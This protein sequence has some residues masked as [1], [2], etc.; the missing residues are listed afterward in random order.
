M[1]FWGLKY[2]NT[3]AQERLCR[4]IWAWGIGFDLEFIS[5]QFPCVFVFVFFYVFAYMCISVFVNLR[6]CI[7]QTYLSMKDWFWSRIHRRP[8]LLPLYL[9]SANLAFEGFEERGR[10]GARVLQKPPICS[11]LAQPGLQTY[12]HLG[13][14]Q[15]IR[16]EIHQMRQIGKIVFFQ[17]NSYSFRSSGL[18]NTPE[19][20][21]GKCNLRKSLC[22]RY[23]SKAFQKN[24]K[25]LE[26]EKYACT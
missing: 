5:T 10:R 2:G 6:I 8:N 4:R 16:M 7:L 26:W 12:F 14:Y 22:C 25:T 1:K 15:Q 18:H 20:L 13:I 11:S 19:D 17:C 3:A 9:P 23:I 24:N 21:A